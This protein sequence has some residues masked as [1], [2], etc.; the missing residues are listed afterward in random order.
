MDIGAANRGSMDLDQHIVVANTRLL[1]IFSQMP[2]SAFAF[3]SARMVMLSLNYTQ[4]AAD[5][6]EGRDCMVYILRCQS[7]RHLCSDTGLALGTTGKENP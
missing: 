2:L 7:R 5:V 4:L 6:A 1:D 3:T